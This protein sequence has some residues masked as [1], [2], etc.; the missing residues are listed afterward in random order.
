MLSLS[1]DARQ[2]ERRQA[3]ILFADISGF[4]SLSE[5][6]DPETVAG[7]MSEIYAI[8]G[9]A[10][11]DRGGLIC[12]FIGDCLMALFGAPRA[13]EHAPWRALDAALEMR[14]RLRDFFASRNLAQTLGIH[15]GLNSGEIFSGSIGSDSRQEYTAYGDAV[16]VASRLKDAAPK[17]TIF[18]GPQTYQQT[19]DRYEY[20][21]M[22]PIAL[23]GKE[24]PVPVY[25]L[26]SRKAGPA[27]GRMI[28]SPLVG[29]QK[30]LDL[31][32]LHVLKAIDGEGSIVHVIGEAGAWQVA[33]GCGAAEHGVHEAGDPPGGTGAVIRREP[34]LSPHRRSSAEL[35]RGP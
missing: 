25:E 22:Q 18:V 23:K 26:L 34:E 19:A 7:L 17:G 12:R 13:L 1:E 16:N 10:V 28:S 4:T 21:V 14:E 11:E 9:K 20:R 30:E 15:T 24:N 35:G 33:A 32:E 2:G 8:L 29:R 6:M 27:R 3:T 31:L 5:T